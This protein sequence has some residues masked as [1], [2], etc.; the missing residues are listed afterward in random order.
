MMGLGIDL[1]RVRW[2]A[3][4][5]LVSALLSS[6]VLVPA[7]SAVNQKSALID[8]EHSPLV[9]LGRSGEI[10][11]WNGTDQPWPQQGR[12]PQRQSTPP[13]H[14]TDGGAGDGKPEDA[15]LLGT[16]TSPALSWAHGSSSIDTDALSS[17]VGD[18]SSSMSVDSVAEERCGGASL[19]PVVVQRRDVGGTDHSFLTIIEGEDAVTAWEVD[20][21]ANGQ[22]KAAPMI[23][24]LDEDGK[25]EIVVV[26]DSQDILTVQAWSPRLECGATGWKSSGHSGEIWW[27]YTDETLRISSDDGPYT[28]G[29]VGDHHPTAQP[30]IAD[31]DLDGAPELAIPAVDVV[32]DRPV[33]VALPLP[34]GGTPTPMWTATLTKGTH[35]SDLAWAMLDSESSAILLT[36][37]D[38]DDGSMWA[39]RLDGET[40]ASQW[41]GSNL[42]NLDGGSSNAPHIRLPGPIVVQLDSDDAPEIVVTIPTDFDGAGTSDGAEFVALEAT[43]GAEIWKARTN[44][45]YADAAPVAIDTDA[46]GIDDRICWVTWVHTNS[47]RY[48]ST[49]CHDVSG[50]TP[51]RDWTRTLEHSSGNPND[52]IAV[53]SPVWMDI[54]GSEPPELLVAYGR[55]IWALDGDSGNG[56]DVSADWSDDFSLPHRTWASPALADVD[57]DALLDIVVGGTVVSQSIANVRPF[58]DF[59]GIDFNPSAP[60]PDQNVTV[61]AYVENA[62]TSV[63]DQDVDVVLKADGVEIGR[64]RLGLLD[65][66]APSGSGSFGSFSVQWSGG[67]GSHDFSIEVDPNGNVT[68][69]RVDDDIMHRELNIVA[70]YNVSIGAPAEPL[71]VDP[72]SSAIAA[73]VITSTG[74]LSGDWTLQVDSSGLPDGWTWSD[75]TEGGITNVSI[76]VGRTWTPMLRISAPANAPGTDSGHLT[77]S[78]YASQEPETLISTPFPVEANRTR[79][80]SVRGPDGTNQTHGHGRILA[81]AS[82]WFIVE[83]LGNA[84]ETTSRISWESTAWGSDLRL[85]DANGAEHPTLTIGA[86]ESIELTAR[87]TVDDSNDGVDLGD[88]VSTPLSICIGG[89]DEEMCESLTVT[90][91]ANE[92][93]LNPPHVRSIP[94]TNLTWP[95]SAH[96]PAGSSHLEWSLASAGMSNPGWEWDGTGA[97]SVTGDVIYIHGASDSTVTGS[98]VLTLPDDAAPGFHTFT[99]VEG[100]HSGA[101]LDFSLH[102][103]QVHR[104]SV[105]AISPLESPHRFTVGE[106][107]TATLRMENRGNGPDTYS[108]SST[109]VMDGNLSVDPGLTVVFPSPTLSLGPGALTTIPVTITSPASTPARIPFTIRIDMTSLGDTMVSDSVEF[110]L[111]ARQDHRWNLSMYSAGSP[112]PDGG[113]LFTAPGQTASIDFL[114][115]NIG[116]HDDSIDLSGTISVAAVGSDS[117]TGWDLADAAIG[118]IDVGENG[119]ATVEVTAPS[120]A[121]NGTVANVSLI[122]SS[123]GFVV[124]RLNVKIEVIHIS[125]WAVYASGVDLDIDPTGDSLTLQVEQR[126]NSPTRPSFTTWVSGSLDWQVNISSQPGDL[127]PESKGD[128]VLYITPPPTARAGHSVE[129]HVRVRN[130]DSSGISEVTFPVRVAAT[131]DHRLHGAD[132][133][134][135]SPQGGMPLAWIENL[136]NGPSS[137]DIEI[138]GVPTGWDI[139]SLTKIHLALGESTGIPIELIPSNWSGDDFSVTIRTTDGGGVQRELLLQ[140]RNTSRTWASSPLLKVIEGDSIDL[141]L[142]GSTSSSSAK[143]EGGSVLLRSGEAFAWKP[144]S[145]DEGNGSLDIDGVSL[146]FHAIIHETETRTVSCSI[147][148]SLNQSDQGICSVGNGTTAFSYTVVLTNE[149]GAVVSLSEGEVA[150]ETPSQFTLTHSWAP[151]PGERILTVRVIDSQGATR[152]ISSGSFMVRNT[153][154]NLGIV[155]VEMEGSSGDQRLSIS[156]K[157]SDH[158]LLIDADC[159]L[160]I[161]AD[162]WNSTHVVDVVG[163][164]AP[165]FRIDRPPLPD[166]TEIAVTLGCAAPWDIDSDP[167]D[168]EKR[169]AL[170]GQTAVVGGGIDAIAGIGS[171]AIVFLMMWILGIIQPRPAPPPKPQRKEKKP[172]SRTEP[173]PR[174]EAE[175]E[176]ISLEYGDVEDDPVEESTEGAGPSPSEERKQENRSAPDDTDESKF[177]EIDEIEVIEE[178]PVDPEVANLMRRI[179]EAEDDFERRLLNLR[180]SRL[181]RSGRR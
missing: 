40:G 149:N 6:T 81:D 21:G 62:G 132:V 10:E 88:S 112:V 79:G 135:I 75:E 127:D 95:I 125:G 17:V 89:G 181:R 97:A 171:A 153:D 141:R 133:W 109:T 26:F 90:L 114:G 16:I 59:E 162:G 11:P 100:N 35:P 78:L 177:L 56:A 154:W 117:G 15:S 155:A 44:D 107:F 23:A 53:A 138:L 110:V 69:S 174:K 76:G 159:T 20:L 156:T 158:E 86:G 169:F 124:H 25:P 43:S 38:A 102:I 47:N 165:K 49:G 98:I 60:D 137:I 139:K 143:I 77:L 123:D 144:Q 157:R 134:H 93:A 14:A 104:S 148:S 12:T 145:T 39:W 28:A 118:R 46:D 84:E 106:Q 64:E 103:L 108:L 1:P 142:H 55:S 175:D 85:V 18:F 67:L 8:A 147:N 57:G 160:K 92:L 96:I 151:L 163:P 152:S 61:T 121:W 80:L 19:F 34:D 136:G 32:N 178:A 2:T 54:D 63:T 41:S 91:T 128:L 74:R 36:T 105:S 65:P 45:G 66:V 22:M 82:A 101:D 111:E 51:I 167:S 161:V 120:S 3:A 146:P 140:V 70:P 73:P 168:D 179:E 164:V 4:I 71:R 13:A 48:G 131:I 68:Q 170:S 166:S 87:L 172:T 52:E 5:L 115:V 72:G 83:N 58:L 129:L 99:A 130:P 113:T 24:D 50:P 7:S 150:A 180:L 119:S 116:N 173:K 37:I 27:T 31:L 94:S 42:N 30:L 126:G 29:I 122:A 9:S 176:S 33:I